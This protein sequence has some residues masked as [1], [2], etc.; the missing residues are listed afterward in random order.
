MH[1]GGFGF[2]PGRA[3]ASALVAA[4]ALLAYDKL[5]GVA[6]GYGPAAGGRVVQIIGV[7]FT[8]ASGVTFGGTAGTSFSVVSDQLVEVTTPAKAAAAVDVVVQHP[9]GN[10]TLA[11]GYT[12]VAAPSI[13]GASY[14]LATDSFTGGG[15]VNVTSATGIK[16][17]STLALGGVTVGFI[18]VSATAF[19]FHIP[20]IAIGGSGAK[21]LVI[22]SPDGQT[23]TKT[24]AVTYT[25]DSDIAEFT[26]G[27]TMD[28]AAS[29]NGTYR[30]IGA[31]TAAEIVLLQ[32]MSVGPVTYRIKGRCRWYQATG[33]EFT[34]VFVWARL[35][36]AGAY[37]W[38]ATPGSRTLGGLKPAGGGTIELQGVELMGGAIAY[39]QGHV[40]LT[41]A[42]TA[43]ASG[44]CLM[45]GFTR[46]GVD[47][48]IYAGGYGYTGTSP[49]TA[50]SAG[51]A[52][53]APTLSL[54]GTLTLTTAA[55]WVMVGGKYPNTSSNTTAWG[56]AQTGVQSVLPA[57][58][59]GTGIQGTFDSRPSLT[60]VGDAAFFILE[61]SIMHNGTT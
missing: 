51:Q 20:G 8:G 22:T 7:G 43:P 9:N 58:A 41:T 34:G 40:Y 23:G 26:D 15:K 37:T 25:K 52:R 36:T 18:Y 48:L 53:D 29:V 54:G 30:L 13:S 28:A 24:A 3:N 6:V 59:N 33:T 39:H 47:T 46:P 44:R 10:S 2:L 17:G 45:F 42:D 16:A 55:E 56:T 50:A 1:G 21:D 4:S 27:A 14:S 12:Y 32:C 49:R 11:G 57:G 38:G 60:H 5:A 61:T 19:S 31:T 35:G